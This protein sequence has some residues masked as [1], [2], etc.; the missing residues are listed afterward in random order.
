MKLDSSHI[1]LNFKY[2]TWYF[3]TKRI[4]DGDICVKTNRYVNL[5]KKMMQI[6]FQ[7]SV[8]KKK[9]ISLHTFRH[10]RNLNLITSDSFF[11]CTNCFAYFNRKKGIKIINVFELKFHFTGIFLFDRSS[12]WRNWILFK[13]IILLI[14]FILLIFD[15]SLTKW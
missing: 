12:L 8:T 15:A 14:L 5:K 13:L 7:K 4:M 10:F 6:K 1:K 2:K 11:N 3:K 9:N